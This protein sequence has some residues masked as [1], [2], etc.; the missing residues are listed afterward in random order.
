MAPVAPRI[1]LDISFETRTN[2][3]SHFPRQA[4][5]LVKLDGHISW[6]AHHFVKFW[7]IAGA[8]NVVYFHTKCVDEMGQVT[9]QLSEAAGAR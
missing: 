9:G 3:E 6:H 2:H 1:V 7:E 5:C 8:R 4:Q